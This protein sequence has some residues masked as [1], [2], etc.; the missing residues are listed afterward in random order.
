MSARPGAPFGAPQRLGSGSL[1]APALAVAADGRVLVAAAAYNGLELYERPPGG[2]FGPRT[3]LF[4]ASAN[5]TVIAL[6][7]GGA[8]AIAWQN[9]IGEDVIAVVR[10]G[11][12]PFGP[13]VRVLDPTESDFGGSGRSVIAF[14][15]GGP[16]QESG[17]ALSAALGADGRALLVWATD[18][19]GLGTATVTSSGRTEISQLGSPLREPLGPSPLLLADGS[20]ALA[21]TDDH[22]IFTSR[23]VRP[24]V[25]TWRS[26]ALP[27]RPRRRR[28]RSRSAGRGGAPSGPLSR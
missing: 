16:P 6:R 24:G 25:C 18:D 21:W 27:A 15:D 10:D 13:P 14:R 22:S 8:A 7:P 26:R 1:D 3:I 5:N 20:R 19:R 28:L 2:R 23:T 17:E 12:V 4:E 11:P 9:T